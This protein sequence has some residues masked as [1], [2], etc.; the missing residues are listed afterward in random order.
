[1]MP[2]GLV[3]FL[4]GAGPGEPVPGTP[5]WVLPGL[6]NAHDHL[7]FNL[8]PRLG[9][10]P[11]ANSYE[12]G[13]E[14]YRPEQEP[15]CSILRVTK[16]DRLRWGAYRNLLAGVTTVQH[17]NP[18]HWSI[19]NFPVRVPPYTWAHSLDSGRDWQGQYQRSH[20][21][22]PFFIHGAEGVDTVAGQEV[23]VLAKRGLLGPST[24]LIHGI[25][26]DEWAITQLRDTGAAVVWCPTSNFYLYGQTAPVRE[27]LAAGVP[28]ALG[29]DSTISG[30]ADLLCE[31]QAARRL[32]WLSDEALYAMVTSAA[33]RIL[34]QAQTTDFILVAA[35]GAQTAA[36]ALFQ[37]NTETLHLVW[38]QGRVLLAAEPLLPLVTGRLRPVGIDGRLRW[39]WG[40]LPELLRRTTARLG[41][42]SYFEKRL[43]VV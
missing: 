41:Q 38:G 30:S 3:E 5:Y 32:G 15:I 33:S 2:P 10:P 11:Y 31:L 23:R 36:E 29:S 42:R 9:H 26:L 27:L 12:W 16:R 6:V 13:R 19:W 21:G 17:H 8:Y 1:M 20:Q 35:P 7:D 18:W 40:P 24:V 43:T 39:I 34:G 28:V 4:G 37:V 14:V 22:R 25:N